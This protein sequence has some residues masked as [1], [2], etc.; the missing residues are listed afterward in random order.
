MAPNS[1][2]EES[3]PGQNSQYNLYLKLDNKANH[4]A[5]K[6]QSQE[7]VLPLSLSPSLFLQSAVGASVPSLAIPRC[8]VWPLSVASPKR[9]EARDPVLQRR[10]VAYYVIYNACII[11]HEFMRPNSTAHC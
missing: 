10:D 8:H 9:R 1:I 6:N 2:L 4:L 3:F 7:K 5:F 11:A